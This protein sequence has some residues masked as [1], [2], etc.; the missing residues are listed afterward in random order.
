MQ[1]NQLEGVDFHKIAAFNTKKLYQTILCILKKPKASN[2][3]I[4]GIH[5]AYFWESIVF[6]LR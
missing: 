4:A 3:T 6:A 1:H 2:F 5:G